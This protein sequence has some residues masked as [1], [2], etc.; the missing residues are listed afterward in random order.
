MF[1][2]S[3]A[4]VVSKPIAHDDRIHVEY[5]PTQVVTEYFRL[6]FKASRGKPIS[7]I[8]YWSSQ[9]PGHASVVL[10]ADQENLVR[11]KEPGELLGPSDPWIELV[12]QKLHR[13]R[14]RLA[15]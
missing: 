4:R 9:H 1:L 7:G 12:D 13:F 11:A 8:R 14:K 6:E 15:K 2:H 10:F 3:F 5:V